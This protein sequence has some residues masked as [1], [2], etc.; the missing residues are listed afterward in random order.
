MRLKYLSFCIFGLSLSACSSHVI[1]TNAVSQN[2]SVQEQAVHGINALYDYPSYDYRGSIKLNLIQNKSSKNAVQNIS[3]ENDLKFKVDQ[4]LKA[5][6]IPLNKIEKQKLYQSIA[7][8]NLPFQRV[9]PDRNSYFMRQFFND[10]DLTYDGSVHYRKKLI[11]LNL[12]AK[13][14]KP[15]LKVE[16]RIPSVVDLKNYKLYTSFSGVMPYLIAPEN[17][18]KFAYYDFSKYKDYID[19][20]DAKAFVQLL[21]EAGAIN[22]LLAQP[23]QLRVVPVTKQYAELGVVKKIRLD[24]SLEEMLLQSRLFN[25]ANQQY[26]MNQVFK[27]TGQD[28]ASIMQKQQS[29]NIEGEANHQQ[30]EAHAAELATDMADEAELASQTEDLYVPKD[31]TFDVEARKAM[32]QLQIAVQ[33]YLDQEDSIEAKRQGRIADVEEEEKRVSEEDENYL[34]YQQCHDLGQSPQKI[35]YGDVVYCKNTFALNILNVKTSENVEIKQKQ[36]ELTEKFSKYGSDQLLDAHTFKNL[37]LE[38]Q[39]AIDAALPKPEQRQPFVTVVG[40]DRE[41]RIVTVDYDFSQKSKELGTDF[42]FKIDMQVSNY[43]HATAIDQK[44]LNNAKS[45]KEMFKGSFLE[46]V[47][48]KYTKNQSTG[49]LSWDDQ[50]KAL[51]KQTYQQTKSYEK[52]YV[53]VFIAKLTASNPDSV[54]Q[55]SVQELQEIAQVYAYCYADKDVYSPKGAALTKVKALQKKHHLDLYGQFDDDLG[56]SINDLVL[57]IW[58]QG[59]AEQAVTKLLTQYKLPQEVFAQY[60]ADLYAQENDLDQY[61]REQMQK[62]AKILGHVYV[63]MHSRKFSENDLKGIENNLDEYIDYSTFIYTYQAMLDAKVK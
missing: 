46:S 52:T 55:Y 8:Q 59:Q 15:N 4:Y 19:K 35:S 11:S 56:S 36:A 48:G 33:N 31:R 10:L 60:Y 14:N 29:R 32:Y 16:A 54:K 2:K 28:F 63:V 25:T 61:E 37:W 40:L 57:P 45:F 30:E 50:L 1:K 24:S 62:T 39:R 43:G 23:D 47:L 38:N 7:E 34:T 9:F 17:Q 6:Q 44:A 26:S 49:K 18:D 20:I 13:Y 27:V 22:Y 21:K 41:G 3:L 53:A 12:N 58:K 42:K 5:Q 51:A